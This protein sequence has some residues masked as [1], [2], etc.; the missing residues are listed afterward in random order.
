[1]FKNFGYLFHIVIISIFLSIFTGCGYKA[2]PTWGKEKN[3]EVNAS[4]LKVLDINSTLKLKIG[5]K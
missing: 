4:D 5:V 3:Q 1:M 2:P